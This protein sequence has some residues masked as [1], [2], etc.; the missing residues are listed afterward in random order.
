MNRHKGGQQGG[1]AYALLGALALAL[2][3]FGAGFFYGGDAAKEACATEKLAQVADAAKRYDAA[4]QAGAVATT[5]LQT[6]LAASNAFGK[7]IEARLNDVQI[8][9]TRSAAR[10][11]SAPVSAVNRHPDAQSRHPDERRGLPAP[12]DPNF[13]RDDGA[14]SARIAPAPPD[15]GSTEDDGGLLTAGAVSV[16][17]SALAGHFVPA[18]ACRAVDAAAGA[19]AVAAQRSACVEPV[20]V[21]LG[22]AWANH[23]ANA[24]ACREDRVRYARL[25]D[26][27]QRREATQRNDSGVGR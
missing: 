11:C 18:G 3:G 22:E 7:T 9:S 25:I 13:R 4:V 6:E 12:V 1:L 2:A 8:L 14:T 21:G 24:Q 27:L 17:N 16:W 26:Y 15:D 23:A 10:R 20:A 19:D 5:A